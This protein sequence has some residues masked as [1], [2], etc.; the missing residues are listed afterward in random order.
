MGSG[1]E[2]PGGAGPPSGFGERAHVLCISR[3]DP[4]RALCIW[5]PDPLFRPDALF[6]NVGAME[7]HRR[8]PED[9]ERTLRRIDG[10]GYKAYKDIQGIYDFPRF[11]LFIDYV[12]GDPFASPTRARLRVATKHAAFPPDLFSSKSRRV[13]LADYLLRLMDARCRSAQTRRGTGKSG[14]IGVDSPGQEVLERTAAF[15]DEGAIEVRVYIGLPARGRTVLGREAASMMLEDL[16]E[17]VEKSLFYSALG[18]SGRTEV[19][20]HVETNE[21]ADYL[22]AALSE[23]GLVAFIANGS[24]LPRRSGVDERPL[25]K[26]TVV[27][28]K[29]PPSLEVELTLPNRG[30]IAGMGIPGGVTLIVGGGYHGKSTVLNAVQRG[31]YNHVPGDGREFAVTIPSAA[32]I[33]AE[34]G[35]R[36]ERVNI[37]PFIANLPFGED[38]TR[39]STENASGSTSQAANIMEALEAGT[40]LLLTDEDTAATNFMIRDHRMQ[41]LISKDREPITPFVDKIRQAHG[42]LGVSTI[43]VIGGSG[44]YFDVADRVIAMDS[45]LA[46]DVTAEA[47]GIAEKYSTERRREGGDEF[48]NFTPRVPMRESLDASKGRREVKISGRGTGTILFGRYTIDLSAVE[49]IVHPSQVNA[50]GQAIYYARTRYMDGQRSLPEILDLVMEDIGRS[51]LDVI[52]PRRMGDYALF[53]RLELAAALNRLP[54]LRVA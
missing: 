20:G 51:G 49:T 22:R 21:D 44:D 14:L 3:P 32:K 39:F 34:D 53:R 6:Y 43:L 31:I 38:T 2:P 23:K 15:V 10:R 16:P 54:T 12:Q 7:R 29:S 28:F 33:R 18:E 41:E 19:K 11:T 30:E 37:S 8:A 48:G 25:T 45:F 47:R 24:V 5:R 1:I 42:D 13:A 35:R 36:V 52:D 40:K 27:R 17:I 4:I 46:R 26:G 9:L 50:I